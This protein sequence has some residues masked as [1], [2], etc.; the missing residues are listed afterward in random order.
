MEFAQLG[1]FWELGVR[2]TRIRGVPRLIPLVAPHSSPDSRA[3]DSTD[4]AFALRAAAGERVAFEGLVERYG[5]RVRA[6]IEKQVGD[7]H[8]AM[9]LTQD[10]WIRVH[11]ALPRFRSAEEGGR[12]RPWLFSITLNLVRDLLRSR[13]Y[14][15]EREACDELELSPA[16]ERY[17]P[18]G[19]IEEV[20]AIDAALQAVP[21]PFG[22]AM[23]LVDVVG[24]SYQEA[25]DSLGCSLGTLK[26]RVNRGRLAF[27][28]L[29]L[30]FSGDTPS[31]AARTRS[32]HS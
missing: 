7:H 3:D 11:R 23:H 19:R 2:M 20:A 26:S 1:T 15:E 16:S 25:A 30:K 21:E 13:K 27:R 12:F 4:E 5:A 32:E 17:N 29:Y 28:D 6:V 24:T 9:D 18:S 22:A 10:V 31:R 14:Q 8:L